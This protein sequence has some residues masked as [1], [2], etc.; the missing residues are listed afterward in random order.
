MK[1]AN[2]LSA[3]YCGITLSKV[4][5]L[6]VLLLAGVLL[7]LIVRYFERHPD[8]LSSLSN[9][10]PSHVL[11]CL[12]LECMLI[13][14]FALRTLMIMKPLAAM[15]PRFIQWLRIHVIGLGLN[16]FAFQGGDVYRAA[17]A[18][19]HF[20][21]AYANYGSVFL[22]AAWLDIGIGLAAALVLRLTA[23]EA[24][25]S[26]LPA[27]DLVWL[28]AIWVSVAPVGT[29]VLNLLA[30]FSWFPASIS[31]Q[32]KTLL[33]GF[34][35]PT[36]STKML[37]SMFVLGLISFIGLTTM[38]MIVFHGL[39]HPV[40]PYQAALLLIVYRLS[41]AVSITPGNIGVRE[42]SVA[43]ASL[44]LGL[45]AGIGVLCSL[46]LRALRLGGIVT[47]L[48]PMGLHKLTAAVKT[49]AAHGW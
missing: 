48:M 8:V 24:L 42:W 28:L 16:F 41:Q 15:P 19:R 12:A 9:L 38:V 29:I 1:K 21:L 5:R 7:Y 17:M 3:S 31:Q 47:F 10:T 27:E 37:L 35:M 45:D 32:I 4:W 39:G 20:G 33:S 34:W 23:P 44:V 6:G 14:L 40:E 30:R 2:A 46:C 43:G 36:K 11:A 18:K 22:F 13:G 26:A 49:R 25:G